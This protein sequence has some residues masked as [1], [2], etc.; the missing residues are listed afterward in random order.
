MILD[1]GILKHQDNIISDISYA[2]ITITISDRYYSQPML[3][4]NDGNKEW[5]EYF[6]ITSEKF[7]SVYDPSE[8]D[9]K[10]FQNEF[11]ENFLIG[12]GRKLRLIFPE[13]FLELLRPSK[14]DV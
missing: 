6:K 11:Q 1:C 5:A 12:L 8:N 4:L 9:V 2:V 3:A 10:N 14:S 13:V 7:Y